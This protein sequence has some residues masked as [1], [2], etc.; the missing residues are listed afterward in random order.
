MD[1]YVYDLSGDL[2]PV[3]DFG[4]APTALRVIGGDGHERI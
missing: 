4:N 3:L 2:A 1:V